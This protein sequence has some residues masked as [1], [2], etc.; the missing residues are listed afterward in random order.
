MFLF[1][2]LWWVEVMELCFRMDKW[3]T[4]GD[5]D[6][7]STRQSWLLSFWNSSLKLS[8]HIIW[9]FSCWLWYLYSYW[10]WIVHAFY[11]GCLG[12]YFVWLLVYGVIFMGTTSLGVQLF[13]IPYKMA[14]SFLFWGCII[15]SPVIA[16]FRDL[17][18]KLYGT[19]STNQP[20]NLSFVILFP[21]LYF[22]YCSIQLHQLN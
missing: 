1:P 22:S 5:L 8:I 6:M 16:V 4:I 13:W 15:L 7:S 10:N 9:F 2:Q 11:W 20:I 14:S 17:I 12:L 19:K 18:F 3:L 21:H